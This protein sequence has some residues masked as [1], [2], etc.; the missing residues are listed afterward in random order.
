VHLQGDVGAAWLLSGLTTSPHCWEQSPEDLLPKHELV[1]M[2]SCTQGCLW[3]CILQAVLERGRSRSS[4]T[5]TV[6]YKG[7]GRTLRSFK[8]WAKDG[9]G[10]D[11][12]CTASAAAFTLHSHAWDESW[13]GEPELSQQPLEKSPGAEDAQHWLGLQSWGV[14]TPSTTTCSMNCFFAVSLTV[15]PH[16]GQGI[17]PGPLLTVPLP[18]HSQPLLS[19]HF[20][21]WFGCIF[22][23]FST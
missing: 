19:L 22:Q 3:T 1:C 15:G 13:A 17:S 6:P 8:A 16:R 7:R 9:E 11:G 5:T 14:S 20:S 2:S 4:P 21:V 23:V 18:R 10:N 12:T